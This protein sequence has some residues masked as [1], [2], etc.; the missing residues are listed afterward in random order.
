MRPLLGLPSDRDCKIEPKNLGDFVVY[1][2]SA[3]PTRKLTP[4]SLCLYDEAHVPGA[5]DPTFTYGKKA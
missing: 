2:Q 4:G 1:L 3:S 5:T